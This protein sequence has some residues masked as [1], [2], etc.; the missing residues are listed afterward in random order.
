MSPQAH[1]A[2]V[3]DCPFPAGSP[4]VVYL[5]HSPG[6]QQTITSQEAAVRDW[7][8]GHRLAILRVYRDEA[9]SGTSTAGRDDFLAMAD[10]LRDGV[11]LPR[12][13][14]VIVWAFSRFARD[15]DDAQF[16]IGQLRHNHYE[17]HSMTDVIPEGPVGRL[18]ESLYH[19]MNE[20]TARKI[21]K[22]AQRGLH[23]LAEQ[24]YWHGAKPPR[25]YM[26]GPAQGL[27]M[28]KNGT[29]RI[30]HHLVFDP[31]WE[32]RVRGAWQA[33]L[34][35]AT[36]WQVHNEFKLYPSLNSYTTFFAN[37][38]YAGVLKCGELIV[39][40][41]H[42]AYVALADFERIQHQRRVL[43]HNGKAPDGDP[44]HSRRQQSPFLLSGLFYCG[45][46]GA[47][48]SGQ[49]YG[50]VMFYKC[51]R[52]H[53]GGPD[54]CRTPSIV[55]WYVHEFILDWLSANVLT[56][57]Y[58]V[59]DREAINARIGGDR[60]MLQ[61]RRQQLVD[62]LGRLD[63]QVQNLVNSI[64]RLGLTPPIERAI[65]ERQAEARTKE[66]ELAQI[67]AQ[68]NQAE[69]TLGD[70]ALD[71]V[72]GHLREELQGESLV[73]SQRVLRRVLVRA[74]FAGKEMTL[75]Y[76]SPLLERHPIIAPVPPWE[77]E[78]QF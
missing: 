65:Q 1:R 52:R 19:F 31:D 75:Y 37:L 35:G 77:F 42:P 71:Y 64:A 61:S 30:G 8:E 17:V 22:D 67:D 49:R 62:D 41:A 53:R 43:P 5:R 11:I 26:L 66:G 47:A 4:V 38:T 69:I 76:A 68:L 7:C 56:R 57:D 24:K 45:A 16:Y 73:D 55:A 33:K 13:A 2:S 74:E 54:L 40:D 6:D 15:Y 78:S 39:P 36:H 20:D 72:A 46:C 60:S 48:M 14:G 63:G 25:G 58:L 23:W 3:S 59:K 32:P 10:A 34:Q 18:V 21:G 27:G 29:E 70:E 50:G 28:R 12:P 44:Q 51:G 9:R